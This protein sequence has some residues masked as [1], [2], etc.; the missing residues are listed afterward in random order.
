MKTQNI[1]ERFMTGHHLTADYEAWT[2]Y[3]VG[4]DIN[5]TD[6]QLGYDVQGSGETD[7]YSL[8][9]A[10]SGLRYLNGTTVYGISQET[11]VCGD[12][13]YILCFYVETSNGYCFNSDAEKISV[14][15]NGVKVTPREISYNSYWQSYIIFVDAP[16]PAEKKE[17]LTAELYVNESKEAQN[18]TVGGN[19]TLVPTALGGTAPYT[20]QY[21][22]QNVSTGKNITLKDYSSATSY[23][24]ALTSQGE[25]IFTVNVKDSKGTVVATNSVTVVV[26]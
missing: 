23:T 10:N 21:V 12:K 6:H 3:V 26:K 11:E 8:N 16:A 24:G 25:K 1:R 18:L 15:L 7:K 22:M 2:T 14:Y 13:Q 17:E 19:V 9:L 5:E 4:N 20:Y